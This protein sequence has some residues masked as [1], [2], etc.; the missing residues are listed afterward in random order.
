[1]AL[2]TQDVQEICKVRLVLE[3]EALSLCKEHLGLQTERKLSQLLET[4]E[5]IKP[6]NVSYSSLIDLQ[7]HQV[8]WMHARNKYLNECLFASRL[9]YSFSPPMTCSCVDRI[10]HRPF[11]QFAE[12]PINPHMK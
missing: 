8:I 2:N 10:H 1:M 4:L 7:F 12:S 6:Q 3:A 5:S 9:H 11:L